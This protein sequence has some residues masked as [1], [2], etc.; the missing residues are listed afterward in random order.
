MTELEIYNKL[1]GILKDEL[2]VEQ[3]LNPDTALVSEKVL[4]SLDFM[5]YITVI[6]GDYGIKISDEDIVN[7][8]LGV[9]KN[10]ADYIGE[11]S[12]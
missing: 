12:I 6:E 5:N 9:L 11:K 7:R 4:D 3:E 8:Q 2:K 1:V 10:M